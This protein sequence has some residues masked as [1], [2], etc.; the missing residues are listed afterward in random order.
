[1]LQIETNEPSVRKSDSTRLIKPQGSGQDTGGA[2][3]AGFDSFEVAV[4]KDSRTRQIARVAYR[5]IG[6]SWSGAKSEA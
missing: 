6:K 2:R 4:T 3:G 1:M 5:Q